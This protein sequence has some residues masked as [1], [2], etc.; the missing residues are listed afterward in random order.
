M[1]RKYTPKTHPVIAIDFDGTIV[2]DDFPE[3]GKPFKHSIETINDMLKDG[4]EIIIW[5][6]RSGI[7]LH[8]AK[9]LLK[10][11]GLNTTHKNLTFNDHSR[12]MLSRYDSRSSKVGASVYIDDK[13]YGAPKSF[14][15]YW[16]ILHGEFL[17]SYYFSN[18]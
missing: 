11:E 15:N 1:T 9:M 2:K 14:A 16:T 12:Y 3:V 8:N 6:A 13:G 17:G 18:V 5:T 4:Y 10:K 7:N